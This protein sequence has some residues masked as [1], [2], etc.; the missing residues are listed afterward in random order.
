ME[1]LHRHKLYAKLSKCMFVKS[2]L[3][4]L[5]HI[6]RAKGIQVDP[7][8]RSKVKDWP[9]PKGK[10]DMQ[11][12]LGLANYFRMFIMGYEQ[13]VKKDKACARLRM[14]HL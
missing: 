6:I 9:V 3:K 1:L 7:A 10:H 13:L 11:Q 2:E 4:F 5:G 12:F 8:N 14:L